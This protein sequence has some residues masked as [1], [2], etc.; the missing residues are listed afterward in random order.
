MDVNAN[1]TLEMIY[2]ELK[3][4]RKELTM[5]EHAVIPVEKLSTVELG[6]HRKDLEEALKGERTDFRNIKG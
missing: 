1:V 6:A 4:I 5:V 3:S 2:K